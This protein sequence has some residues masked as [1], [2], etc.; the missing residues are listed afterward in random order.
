[1]RPELKK[2]LTTSVTVKPVTGYSE[3]GT[4]TLGAGVVL[5][6]YAELTTRVVPSATGDKRVTATLIVVETPVSPDDRV[7]LAGLDTTDSRLSKRPEQ[8]IVYRDPLAGGAISHCEF[9]L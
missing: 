1:M 6:A 7:W 4:E 9:M 8:V 5:P 3:G 2:L